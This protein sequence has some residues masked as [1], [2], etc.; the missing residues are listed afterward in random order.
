VAEDEIQVMLPRHCLG[1]VA[2]LTNPRGDQPVESARATVAKLQGGLKVRPPLE[3]PQSPASAVMAAR[4]KGLAAEHRGN[5][6]LHLTIS[7]L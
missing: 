2:G 4:K 3:S 6:R 7:K 1:L 5:L